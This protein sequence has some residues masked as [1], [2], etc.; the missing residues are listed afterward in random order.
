MHRDRSYRSPVRG[1][2]RQGGRRRQDSDRIGEQATLRTVAA[3]S[4]RGRYRGNDGDDRTAGDRRAWVGD[5]EG[6]VPRS[7]EDHTIGEEVRADVTAREGVV[8]RYHHA[9]VVV[10]AREVNRTGVISVDILEWV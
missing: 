10:H 9:G 7:D 6:L 4:S 3:A 1:R 2:E 5:R 8:V